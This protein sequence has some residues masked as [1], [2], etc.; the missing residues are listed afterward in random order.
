VNNTLEEIN[1]LNAM[2]LSCAHV[3]FLCF[4]KLHNSQPWEGTT[5]TFYEN[6]TNVKETNATIYF[7]NE[8]LARIFFIFV[9]IIGNMVGLPIENFSNQSL[10]LHFKLV[11]NK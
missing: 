1:A 8:N 4:E 7:G 9:N 5:Y 3:F 2:K 6:S 11:K 10:S